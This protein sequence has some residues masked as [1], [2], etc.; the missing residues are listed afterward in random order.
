MI[1]SAAR[2]VYVVNEFGNSISAYR[3]DSSGALT[4]ISGSPFP[5]GR[6]PIQAALDPT[7]RFLYVANRGSS[8]ISAYSIG[9]NGSLTPVAGSPFA[10]ESDLI[11]W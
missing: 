9:S 2:F 8:D 4:P 5:A 3:I 11:Q 1:D 7:A 6:V 10:A